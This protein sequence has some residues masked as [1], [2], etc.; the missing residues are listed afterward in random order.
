[1]RKLISLSAVNLATQAP[2]LGAPDLTEYRIVR[3]PFPKDVGE[4]DCYR[5]LLGANASH[6]RSPS[7]DKTRIRGD[8]PTAISRNG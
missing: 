6:A 7:R 5:Y 1:M 2:S 8:L 4:R 3:R